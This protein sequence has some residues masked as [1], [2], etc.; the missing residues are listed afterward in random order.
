ML[1]SK[2]EGCWF[3]ICLLVV[4]EIRQSIK[5]V[6]MFLRSPISPERKA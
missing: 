1:D 5:H 3:R 2:L 4:V 6:H